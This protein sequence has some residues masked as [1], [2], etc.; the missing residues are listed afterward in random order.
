MSAHRF[1]KVESFGPEA[2]V[3]SSRAIITRLRK[4]RRP[5][6]GA[7]LCLFAGGCLSI[8]AF[9]EMASLERQSLQQQ[10]RLAADNRASSIQR[11]LGSDFDALASMAAFFRNTHKVTEQEFS[12]FF[13]ELTRGAL[14]HE[15]VSVVGWL[16]RI[17]AEQ[18]AAYEREFFPIREL[19]ANFRLTSAARRR[20]FF[21]V[22][23]T[24]PPG[25]E[26]SL[27]FD[28]NSRATSSPA[29]MKARDS[30]TFALSSQ[31]KLLT[32]K[33]AVFSVFVYLPV[34]QRGS[35][36]AT[37][38][39][40]RRNLLGIIAAAFRLKDVV[41]ASLN[42]LSDTGIDISI[43]DRSASPDR[44]FLY[45]SIKEEMLAIE[46]KVPYRTASKVESRRVIPVGDRLWD[47]RFVPNGHFLGKGYSW[48]NLMVLVCGFLA[49]IAIS[50]YIFVLLDRTDH[51]NNVVLQQTQELRAANEAALAGS[52]AK[53]QFIATV[54]HEL[55][56][57]MNGVLGMTRLLLDTALDDEQ[58]ELAL[59]VDHSAESLLQ[60]LNEI[61]DFSKM[62]AGRLPINKSKFCLR[63]EI[64]AAKALLAREA[65]RKGLSFTVDVDVHDLDWLIGD[66]M[67]LRQVLVNLLSNAIKFT[68]EGSVRLTVT[69]TSREKE[70][71]TLCFMVQDTG[72]GISASDQKKLFEPFTQADSSDTRKHGGTGLGLAICRQL[73]NLM[74]GSIGL[75]S[76]LGVGSAFWFTLTFERVAADSTPQAGALA[77]LATLS[78]IG[79]AGTVLLVEDNPVN[80]TVAKKLL[81][82]LGCTVHVAANGL[83]GIKQWEA[84]EFD[85]V[86]MD[87]QMPV[88]DGFEATAE[89][90]RRE[91]EGSRIWIVALTANVMHQDRD[92][93]ASAGM[94]D[95]LTKPVRAD[96]LAASLRR[97]R[98]A[99]A[100]SSVAV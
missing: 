99:K 42:H 19:D 36:V 100:G 28:V 92:R 16:P 33:G 10:F 88:M 3:N 87:C 82:K 53:S 9:L 58:R 35:I 17:P 26:M 20:E 70:K 66:P 25:N 98:L 46:N 41:G 71:S 79:A 84:Q 78:D 64:A 30:G 65:V 93:C 14:H 49:S 24:A 13:E 69:E 60:L 38:S 57:P 48:P 39:D 18:R 7:L 1:Q 94:S 80:Q 83:E 2:C 91:P 61:L 52:R 45:S 22:T 90:R 68:D 75:Q 73:V 77:A 81:E 51:I 63:D 86:F 50:A 15:G 59:T 85:A 55:R 89:I 29:I 8:A 72:S 23:R 62:E 95:F 44:N 11:E 34:Y 56:T 21:P 97:A 43:Y 37:V 6:V 31:T 47:L 12:H 54:S 32:D 74:K 27:G 40:R 67:R 4:G 96:D 5:L 76:E